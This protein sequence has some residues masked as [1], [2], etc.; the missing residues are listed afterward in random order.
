MHHKSPKS[1]L[2]ILIPALMA[3]HCAVSIGAEPAEQTDSA[4]NASPDAESQHGSLSS[5]QTV[6]VTAEHFRENEETTAIAM[7][8]MS[9][10]SLQSQ[11]V[12]D[13]KSL[14]AIAP[15]VNFTITQGDPILTM[16]GVSSLDTNELGDPAVSVDTDGFYQIRPYALDATLYDIDHVEVLRGPQGTLNGRNSVGGAI[17]IVTADPTNR[18]EGYAML[19]YGNYDDLRTE[20]MLNVPVTS[21]LQMR[22]SFASETHSG[23]RDNSPQPNGDD[24]DNQSGRVKLRLAPLDNW[25]TVLT[26]QYTNMGG[27]GQVSE[28]IPYR[29]ASTG[30]LITNPPPNI[31]PFH[32]SLGFPAGLH[33]SERQGRFRSE[34]TFGTFSL[35]ALG[36]YDQ[37]THSYRQPEPSVPQNGRPLIWAPSEHPDTYNGEIRLSQRTDRFRWQVGF[38][39]FGETMGL[40]SSNEAPYGVNGAFANSFGFKYAVQSRSRAGYG[41]LTWRLT[42]GLSVTAGA[43]YTRDYKEENGYFGSFAYA[44]LVAP[45]PFTVSQHGEAT[46]HKATYLASVQDQLTPNAM[47]YAKVATGYKAGGFNLGATTYAPETETSFESGVKGRFLND[48]LQLNADGYFANDT[49]QQV[50]S[51]VMVSGQPLALIENAGTSHIYGF[52]ADGAGIWPRLGTARLSVNYLHARYTQFNAAPDPSDPTA[53]ATNV[54]LAGNAMPQSPNLTLVASFEHTWLIGAG[55]LSARWQ[56]K[57]ATRSYFSFYNTADTE[58]HPYAVSDFTLTAVLNPSALEIGAYVRNLT[59][60]VVYADAE[61]D[62]YAYSYLYAFQPP[63]TWGVQV[64]Y[65]FG[66]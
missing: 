33:L 38:F 24:A 9:G 1:S 35:T 48:R 30:A 58:Q 46:W 37:M 17:N 47:V 41:Q 56:T 5:L 52:E 57:Y 64:K 63:R 66:E 3:L 8:V 40:F 60:R 34:Y 19:S 43:R 53:L 59:N 18:S 28:F 42:D 13:M 62:Q 65:H 10:S 2:A 29:Y 49:G 54:D 39:A 15:D 55:T 25:V 26:L 16:R 36:G 23:Y 21:W 32:F 7:S 27:A 14:S 20:A 22:G 44:G 51:Y 4:G 45:S 31:D 50:S 12:T 6:V 11:G 61:E